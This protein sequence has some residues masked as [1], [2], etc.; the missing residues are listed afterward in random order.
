MRQPLGRDD[1]FW[2]TPYV[3]QTIKRI[4]PSEVKRLR[5]D[6][7]TNF[8]KQF[9]QEVWCDAPFDAECHHV[10]PLALGGRN[11]KDNMVLIEPKLH[12]FIHVLISRQ[13][14]AMHYGS[15]KKIKL[16]KFNGVIWGYRW[17]TPR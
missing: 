2:Y 10:I 17:P 11:S 13:I 8:S 15:E 6:F 5:E 7:S 4:H 14:G 3:L 1:D 12:Q 9:R 16:P